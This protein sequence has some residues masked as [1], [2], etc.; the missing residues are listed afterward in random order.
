MMTY[1]NIF[2]YE[3]RR[4]K[5]GV[6]EKENNV[7]RSFL[8]TLQNCPPFA[9]HIF[10]KLDITI[11]KDVNYIFQ[12]NQ[13]EVNTLKRRPNK[14]F[15]YISKET[16]VEFEGQKT[17]NNPLPDGLITDEKNIILIEAKVNAPIDNS[18]KRIYKE[19]FF[20][21]NCI[22]KEITWEEIHLISKSFLKKNQQN[23]KGVELFIIDE[24][25]K[26][27]E[28]INLNSFDGITFFNKEENYDNVLAKQTLKQL[29]LEYPKFK[30][31]KIF[32]PKRPLEGNWD[33]IYILGNEKM[34]THYTISLNES[35]FNIDI[36][37][38]GNIGKKVIKNCYDD[39]IIQIKELSQNDDYYLELIDYHKVRNKRLEKGKNHVQRGKDYCSLQFSIQLS[40]LVGQKNWEEKLKEIML[41]H[42]ESGIKNLQIKKQFLFFDEYYQ[43]DLIMSDKKLSLDEI[44]K[45]LIEL[46]PLYLLFSQSEKYKSN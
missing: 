19:R 3:P 40:K 24:F 22:E 41:I 28:A 17:T 1:L 2:N 8:T 20:N 23:L 25:R 10:S 31:I 9:R 5:I 42:F 4:K 46:K 37:T 12:T 6:D 16:S 30:D 15:L 45:T 34:R 27:L 44:N 21:N 7:T 11:Q 43:K 13:K 14:Y 39:F 26:Y 18:Q 29:R 38:F 35:S 32:I 33:P 36:M